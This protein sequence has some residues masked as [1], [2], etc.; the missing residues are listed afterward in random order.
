NAP[1]TAEPFQ[2]KTLLKFSYGHILEEYILLLA[3]AAG[4]SVEGMQDEVVLNGVRG[5]RDVVVDGCVV[6][7]KSVNSRSFQ[8]FKTGALAQDDRFGYLDQL[9]GY[10]VG[11]ADDPLVL[12][13]DKAY[14]FAVDQELGGLCL[15]EHN[16][17]KTIVNQIEKCKAI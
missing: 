10:T 12:V 5:H 14:I 8:K 9:D 3:K 6:D 11:S 13:K 2:G 15:Y 1:E 17:R 4:H 16:V 7:V